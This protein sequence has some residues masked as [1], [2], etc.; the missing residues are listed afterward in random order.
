M[1]IKK[2]TILV[3]IIVFG[4]STAMLSS[5]P[6][7]VSDEEM[8]SRFVGEW[9]NTEYG[10]NRAKSMVYTNYNQ[11]RVFD[12]DMVGKEW[13]TIDDSERNAEYKITP[14]EFWIDENG[15]TSC[16]LWWDGIFPETGSYL[17]FAGPALF[18]VSSLGT[19][20]ECYYMY[21]ARENSSDSMKEMAFKILKA[22]PERS[23][24]NTGAYLIY[25]RMEDAQE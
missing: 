18:K 14:R 22:D 4:I 11:K 23:I 13:K 24:Q 17:V 16:L 9:V 3:S 12:A 10:Y 19:V 7:E 21:G 20:L 15:V 6:Q 25:S 8:W 2:W 5:E 1:N